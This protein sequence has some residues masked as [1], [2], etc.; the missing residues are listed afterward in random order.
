MIL[1]YID[2]AYYINIE[3]RTDKRDAIEKQFSTMGIPVNRFNAIVLGDS[4]LD[5][6]QGCAKSHQAVLKEA[7]D[8]G[9][10]NVW[11]LEDDCKFVDGFMDKAQQ[12]INE[13]KTLD[14]DVFYF[15]GEPNRKAEKHLNTMVKTN[16]AYG[17]HSYLVNHTFYDKIISINNLGPIDMVYLNYFDSEKIFYISKELLAIQDWELSS[18]IIGYCIHR[19]EHYKMAYKM[20]ID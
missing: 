2:A 17:L 19:E 12:C 8:K 3:S 18:D 11:I 13:L 14:W 20:Y 16:G 5:K 7:K 15:G 1:D 10:K 9:L 6:E 4:K